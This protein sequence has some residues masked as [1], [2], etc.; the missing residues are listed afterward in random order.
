MGLYLTIYPLR[1]TDVLSGSECFVRDSLTFEQ[2]DR[3][4]GLILWGDDDTL[5]I[6]TFPL[7]PGLWVEK[8]GDEGLV[9]TRKDGLGGEL[10]FAYAGAL[11]RLQIPEDTSF[12]NKAIMAS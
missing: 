2:D 3:I 9:R 8:Y 10:R 4:F 11:K 7:P 12:R 6:E 1:D 5:P